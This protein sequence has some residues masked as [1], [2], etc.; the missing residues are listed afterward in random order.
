MIKQNS[1]SDE[2]NDPRL[3]QAANWAAA[4]LGLDEVKLEPVSGDASFR[5]YFR[6]CAGD[7]SVI[8]MDAPPDREN[9]APFVDIDRRLRKAGLNAPEI[10]QFDLARG[11]GLLEDFGDTLYRDILDERSVDELF[12]PLFTT[13]INMATNV[14]T[15]GLAGYDAL[16]LQQEMDLFPNWYLRAHI[17]RKF[18]STEQF[19][20]NETC[21]S[22]I[23]S[24]Y[25]QPRVFV[26][27]DFHSCNVLQTDSGETGIIDFQ[28]G[29]SGPL[30]Y[31]FVS[32]LWDRYI[33]WPRD[34]LETWMKEFHSHL[35]PECDLNTWIRWC[36]LMSVQRNLKIVGIFAR[37]NYRD[38]KNAYLEMIPLFYAYL[39]NVVLRYPEYRDFYD[40]LEQFE[41]AP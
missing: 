33:D 7:R 16:L 27:K 9:S 26:H 24:A 3:S 34:H 6:F 20:W 18:S 2:Q 1:R 28:D 37:L 21:T 12:P 40:L 17:K 4:T 30:S 22:L 23:R 25:E 32:L 8:L 39:R 5:R 14:N 31:D 38:G 36:D 10:F 29:L 15:D 35:K 11:F 41:C 19:L 13:L